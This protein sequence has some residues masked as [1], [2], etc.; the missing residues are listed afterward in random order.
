MALT[1]MVSAFA[2]L[3]HASPILLPRADNS[4]S[5]FVF[6]NSLGL[7]F[8]QTNGSLQDVTIFATGSSSANYREFLY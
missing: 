2:G 8:T 1:L 3:G 7:N 4:T 5:P 6:T